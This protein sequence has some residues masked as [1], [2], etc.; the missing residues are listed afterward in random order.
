MVTNVGPPPDD[1]EELDEVVAEE[2]E[3]RDEA[4]VDTTTPPLD[5]DEEELELITPEV[6][7]PPL[8]VARDEELVLAEEALVATEEELAADEALL[9]EVWAEEPPADDVDEVPLAALDDE[10]ELDVS[11]A[12]EVPLTDEEDTP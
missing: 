10:E 7:E 1:V 3:V 2:L 8:L 5:D 6:V 11:P 9:V 4:E 12:V